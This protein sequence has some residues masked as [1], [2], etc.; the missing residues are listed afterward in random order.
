MADLTFAENVLDDGDRRPGAPR[1]RWRTYVRRLA[2][3]PD[4]PKPLYE[5][6]MWRTAALEA[7][8]MFPLLAI[9]DPGWA[10]TILRHTAVKRW[11][12]RGYIAM[13][14]LEDDPA[15]E[16][17]LVHDPLEDDAFDAWIGANL[18][19]ETLGTGIAWHW[20][21]GVISGC[22]PDR[23]QCWTD[24]PPEVIHRVLGGLVERVEAFAR[25]KGLLRG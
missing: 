9:V 7:N 15:G 5:K 8:L 2:Q 20:L 13:F 23:V 4:L 14:A 17:N 10:D 11:E 25:K 21:D 6:L 19:D 16:R 1:R 12:L 24:Y 22:K 18:P 3:N